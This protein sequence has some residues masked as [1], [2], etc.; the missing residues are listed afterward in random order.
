MNR[1]CRVASR[2]ANFYPDR[3]TAFA[4][5]A[6]GYSPPNTVANWVQ[7]NQMIKGLLKR[8]ITGYQTWFSEDD[9]AKVLEDKVRIPCNSVPLSYLY[10][11]N[12]THHYARSSTRSSA[13]SSP[14]T[15]KYGRNTSGLQEQRKLGSR[16]VNKHRFRHTSRR[17]TRNTSKRHSSTGGSKRR[18]IGIR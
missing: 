8:D 14:P 4:F 10:W 13:F 9:T 15:R 2:L 3:F 16:A 11:H 1:G 17:R 7:T 6:V 18:R 5:F 12:P